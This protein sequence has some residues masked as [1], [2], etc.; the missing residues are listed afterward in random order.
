MLQQDFEHDIMRIKRGV[1]HKHC[2]LVC[3]LGLCEISEPMDS[4]KS[5][6]MLDKYSLVRVHQEEHGRIMLAFMF[7]MHI[8]EVHQEYSRLIVLHYIVRRE[9]SRELDQ[10]QS[11]C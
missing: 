7:H 4:N 10:E 2:S 3:L 5:G 8:E 9:T 1:Q 6:N 11:Q